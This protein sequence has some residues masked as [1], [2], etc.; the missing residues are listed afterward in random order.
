LELIRQGLAHSKTVWLEGIE[1]SSP[2]SRLPTDYLGQERKNE[3]WMITET[4]P[5][6]T[7]QE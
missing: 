7:R 4:K 2:L 1:N 3:A 6:N 5:V